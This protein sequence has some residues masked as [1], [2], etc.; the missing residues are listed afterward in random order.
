MKKTLLGTFVVALL[1]CSFQVNSQNQRSNS[2]RIQQLPSGHQLRSAFDGLPPQ[3]KSRAENWLNRLG[4]IPEEDFNSIGIDKHG[5]VYYSDNFSS[6]AEYSDSSSS[7]PV[8]GQ[9]TPTINE[10]FTLHSNPGAPYTVY[11]DFDGMTITDRRWNE[12]DNVATFEARPYDRDGNESSF[13]EN[14]RSN[15]ASIWQRVSDDFAAFNIDVTTEEPA[16]FGPYVGHV[17]ITHSVDANNVSMPGG[18]GGIAYV[19]IF[20]YGTN[21]FYSPALV[22]YNA[23]GQEHGNANTVSHE[24]GHNL[25]LSHHGGGGDGDYYSGHGSGFTSWAPLMGS[26]YT[27]NVTQWDHGSYSGANNSSQDDINEIVSKLSYRPDD[28]GN[29]INSATPLVVQS[30]GTVGVIHEELDPFDLT[31]NNKGVIGSSS[32][33]DFF[34]FS[35]TGGLINLNI[36]PSYKAFDYDT[37]RSSN[38]DINAK[39]YNSSGSLINTFSLSN[40]IKADISDNL[41]AG[42]YYISIEGEGSSNYSDYS[43]LGKYYIS[44]T[45]NGGVGTVET[46][47]FAMLGDFGENDSDAADVANMVNAWDIDFVTTAG[48]NRY[49]SIDFHQAIGNK[50]CQWIA[51]PG[52]NCSGSAADNR[53]FPSP[54][55]HD[56]SDGGGISEYLNYFDLPGNGTNSTNTSGNERYYDVIQ[57]D[58]HLFMIDSDEARRS[59]SNRAAQQ[60]W[61]QTQLAASTANWKVVLMHHA[62]HS[63]GNHGSDPVMQWPFATWGADVVMSGHDHHYE[64]IHKDGIVYIVNGLGGRSIYGVGSP[65]SGSQ[66]LYNGDYGAVLA[67]VD[68]NTM[69]IKFINVSGG[70]IDDYDITKSATPPN[71]GII[72]SQVSGSL[73]DV[74]ENLANGSIDATSTDLELVQDSSRSRDQAVGLLFRNINIPQGAAVTSAYLEFAVDEIETAPTSIVIKAQNADN[75]TD[76]TTATN[77]I[78]NRTVTSVSVAWSNIPEWN[79]VGNFKQS[80]DLTLLV[81]EVVDRPGWSSGNKMAFIITGTGERTVESFDGSPGGAARLHIEY[82]NNTN[83]DPVASYTTTIT[84]LEVNFTDTSTDSDGAVVG[85][86]WDFGDGNTSNLQNP[87]H[88]YASAGSYNVSLTVTD[89]SGGTHNVS[90][91]VS[92][93]E[94]PTSGTVDVQISGSL[95]DVE[96]RASDGVVD[97]NSSDI[98]LGDDPGFNEDQ[99]VGLLFRNIVI[100]QGSIIASAYL[101]FEVDEIDTGVTNVS[102][103]VENVDDAADF[104]IVTNNVTNRT[105]TSAIVNWD[106]PAWNTTSEKKQSPDISALIQEIIDRNG[107]TAGNKM[108]FIISGT[109]SRTAEAYDGEPAN[110]AKLHIEYSEPIPNSAP[111]ANF[112]SNVTDRSVLFMETSTD[113]DGSIVSWSWDFGDGNTSSAQNSIHNYATDDTFSVSLTVT[114]DDGAT[115]VI[116]QDVTTCLDSDGDGVC[117]DQDVCPD[118]DDSIDTDGDGT[119]D[120]CDTC[121]NSATGD[122]DGDGV[123]DDLDICPGGDDNIDSDGDGIPD[124]CDSCNDTVDTDNDGYND[125]IDLEPNS[126]CPSN[127]DANGVSIDTDGDGVADCLDICY[128]GDDNSDSDNDGTPDFCD[129]EECDGVDND[130]DGQVDEGFTDTDNDGIADCVD[131]E[132][133]DGLDNDGDGQIDEGFTDTDGDGTADCVDTEECD[134][135]DNDGDGQIDEGFTDTDNDGI[136]DCIDTEECDGIDN[137]GDGQIDEGFTDT[138]NDGIADCVDTEECDGLDNDGDGL[139]DEGFTDTDDDGIAD[140]VDTEECD[141][142]DND[143]DGL[144]DE[145]YPDSDND[146]IA[147]CVDTTTCVADSTAFSPSTLTHTGTGLTDSSASIPVDGQDISFTISGM[148]HRTGGKPTNRFIEEVSVSYVD[149]SGA[150]QNYGTFG[151]GNS[152]VNVSI[153]GVVQSITVELTDGYDGNT[154]QN[155]SVNLSDVDF[156]VETITCLDADGDGI[157]NDNDLEPGSLCPNNV[158]ADGVSID[159]DADGVCDDLDNCPNTANPNQEDSDGDGVGDVCDTCPNDPDNDKDGDGVCGDSDNCPLVANPDQM[160]TD[161]DGIGDACDEPVTC[162]TMYIQASTL[163]YSGSP[164]SNTIVVNG[165]GVLFTISDLDQRTGGKPSNRYIE[166]VTVSYSPGGG[167]TDIIYGVYS[168]SSSINVDIGANVFV[169]SV[170][171]SLADGYD[172]NYGNTMSVEIGQISYCGQS[173]PALPEAS[174]STSSGDIQEEGIKVYPNPASNILNVSFKGV[175]KLGGNISLYSFNGQLIMSEKLT[176]T[177]SQLE[178]G[179]FAEGIYMLMINDENGASILNRRIIIRR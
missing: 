104:E 127:V 49:G 32:D 60:N 61:L 159:S 95:D 113:S 20:G 76:F 79:D 128:G 175:E 63:S 46:T 118:F 102:I 122:S 169:E 150:T 152:S 13:S 126:P 69:N 89:N 142:L 114:D 57:G 151:S 22:Y 179:D 51:N 87:S 168:G 94:I 25:G 146:G 81:Q 38:L 103:A 37:Y 147:D 64:R 130:G 15:I 149:G 100:P 19:D 78:T 62:P 41:S 86:S 121:P 8:V 157:C 110:A 145:G 27:K 71:N 43:S 177:K 136:A 4:D 163:L 116:S 88:I 85:W 56:Y 109:G 10:I 124:F 156:C 70:T 66:V 93:A 26:Y 59:S 84:G 16:N 90:Q 3:A 138:D 120:G 36:T 72:D 140:C 5:G 125:C 117:D 75:A 106:I 39:L 35:T 176:K 47:N 99:T 21:V 97:E 105:T 12:R 108:A 65:I 80:P 50:Y 174:L 137:D 23:T 144:V 83:V 173:A 164:S 98:E 14:E 7:E 6:H 28:H 67:S 82:D 170:T 52:I 148:N 143:G 107:W 131:T 115:D 24:F 33:L 129:V 45:I 162:I 53:F 9:A 74:E 167:A 112:T 40:D 135:L 2:Q 96:E 139:V 161:E 166:E 17:L 44:G 1:F 111:E 165:E 11:L 119:P 73:D 154:N 48:D 91:N 160:D 134:G 133:C 171:V 132:E 31:T 42:S 55:N 54:G 153:S 141:G 68:G 30:D 155:L 34:S 77:N 58:V 178:L 29:D 172:N 101:E 158:D 123:C 92:V 18:G